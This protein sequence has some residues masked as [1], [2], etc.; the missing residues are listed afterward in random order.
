MIGRSLRISPGYNVW[1]Y[2]GGEKVIKF[3]VGGRVTIVKSLNKDIW[4]A[5][6]DKGPLG[7]EGKQ[8]VIPHYDIHE[9]VV[10]W[11][12]KTYHKPTLS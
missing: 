9:D 2:E 4:L 3:P 5:R 1:L 11:S 8:V 6:V 12:G 10:S 7:T